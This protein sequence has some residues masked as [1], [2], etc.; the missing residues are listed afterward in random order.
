MFETGNANVAR[1]ADRDGD[2]GRLFVTFVGEENGRVQ[3][4]T[5][6]PLPPR[7]ICDCHASPPSIRTQMSCGDI[8]HNSPRNVTD[9]SPQKS[10]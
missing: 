4:L 10:G 3:T 7:N 2:S 1:V 5:S 8:G 9:V 6:T